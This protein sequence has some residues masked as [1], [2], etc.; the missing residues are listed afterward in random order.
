M[1]DRSISVTSNLAQAL[2]RLRQH[3]TPRLIWVDA[4]CIHQQNEG[5]KQQQI[6]LMAEIYA[7][8]SDVIVWLG[9]G[10]DGG[11][12]A[13]ESI[14]IVGES[15]MRRVEVERFNPSVQMLL[16]RNWFQRIWVIS[17]LHSVRRLTKAHVGSTGGCRSAS[18][19][20]H[21]WCGGDRCTRLLCRF[22]GFA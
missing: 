17:H 20:D 9:D 11:E 8:A 4:L 3:S 7:R 1:G 21:V 10:Q 16:K 2:L 22:K 6:Q 15:V 14:R 18:Y 12:S 5:E 13:L 19:P